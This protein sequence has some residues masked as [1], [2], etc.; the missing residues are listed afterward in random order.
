MNEEKRINQGYEIIDSRTIGSTEF[1]IGHNPKAPNPYVC[2]HCKDSTDYYWGYYTNTLDA[3]REKM[4]ER[5][6]TA[7]RRLN[8]EHQ[9]P[10]KSRDDRER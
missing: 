5:C 4:M 2:W 1:V 8:N 10:P 6:E 3:A 9:K 7:A